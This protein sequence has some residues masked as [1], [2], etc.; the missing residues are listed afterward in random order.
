[1]AIIN[2]ILSLEVP[3]AFEDILTAMYKCFQQ[4]KEMIFFLVLFR[5]S[6]LMLTCPEKENTKSWITS[7]GKEVWLHESSWLWSSL[8]HDTLAHEN[9]PIII[10]AQYSA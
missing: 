1:M 5:S 4:L 2:G 7:D 10:Q 8:Q 9:K 6:C 3:N